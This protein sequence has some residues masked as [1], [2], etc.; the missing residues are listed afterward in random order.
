MTRTRTKG[1][2]ALLSF[3][4]ALALTAAL[5]ACGSDEPSGVTGPDRTASTPTE[6][7]ASPAPTP[8]TTGTVGAPTVAVASEPAATTAPTATVAPTPTAEPPQVINTLAPAT[9]PLAPQN[10]TAVLNEDGSVILSWDAPDDD[11]IT[12]YQILRQRPTEGEDELLVYVEDTRSTATS[13]TDVEVTTSMQR[14]YRVKA[15]NDTGVSEASNS[16]Q[17]DL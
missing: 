6:T 3:V 8:S 7:P 15:V 2:V 9:P 14:V 11:W 4:L 1:Y 17:V 16:A 5:A 13:Y 10:L 12:G